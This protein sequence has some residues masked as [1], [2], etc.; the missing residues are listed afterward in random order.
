MHC[1]GG[2]Q[3]WFEEHRFSVSC[4]HHTCF[5][6]VMYPITCLMQ[7]LYPAFNLHAFSAVTDLS[8]IIPWLLTFDKGDY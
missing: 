2:D 1:E 5:Q 7:A 4:I 8:L 3:T 6:H